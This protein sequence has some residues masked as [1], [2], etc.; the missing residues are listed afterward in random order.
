MKPSKALFTKTNRSEE[1]KPTMKPSKRKKEKTNVKRCD[2]VKMKHRA[3]GYDAKNESKTQSACR[4]KAAPDKG[5][6]GDIAKY[7]IFTSL[8]LRPPSALHHHSS[9][10]PRS[11]ILPSSPKTLLPR[12]VSDCTCSA[13]RSTD[14]CVSLGHHS[15]H[16]HLASHPS[17]RLLPSPNSAA[18]THQ[19]EDTDA[20][21]RRQE[22]C[23]P[24]L[25]SN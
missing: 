4:A 18:G 19:T 14:C 25:Q 17:L 24:A 20:P 5:G 12:L 13:Q 6:C 10:L 7:D 21:I 8:S 23:R 22:P 1:K 3:P 9:P 2:L 16:L 11:T 15:L